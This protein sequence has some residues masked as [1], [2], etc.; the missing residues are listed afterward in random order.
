M[1]YTRK[2]KLFPEGIDLEK[3]AK[4]KALL[5]VF[6]VVVDCGGGDAALAH[7]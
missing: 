4:S 2:G 6:E 1:N 7:G 5:F 3:D